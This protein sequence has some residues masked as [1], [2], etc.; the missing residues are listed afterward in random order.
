MGSLYE[1]TGRWSPLR[2]AIYYLGDVTCLHCILRSMNRELY[3]QRWLT[4]VWAVTVSNAAQIKQFYLPQTDSVCIHFTLTC[5]PITLSCF[6]KKNKKSTLHKLLLT[7]AK[8]KISKKKGIVQKKTT[9]KYHFFFFCLGHINSIMFPESQKINANILYDWLLQA[10]SMCF[11]YISLCWKNNLYDYLHLI[12]HFQG[13]VTGCIY[14]P[15][16]LL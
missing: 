2:P 1:V 8:F 9:L 10:A 12:C 3:I 15:P 4:S 14:S 11:L 16:P 13:N 5:F 7:S 6:R